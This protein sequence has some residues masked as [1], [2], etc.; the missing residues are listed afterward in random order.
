MVTP[1]M[2]AHRS[3]R[4]TETILWFIEHGLD[5]NVRC[6]WKRSTPYELEMGVTDNSINLLQVSTTI[7]EKKDESHATREHPS[8]DNKE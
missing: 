1:I 3:K 7:R 4:S 5:P 8:L 6:G 2:Y